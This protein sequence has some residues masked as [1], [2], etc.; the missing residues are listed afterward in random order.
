MLSD[1]SEHLVA[2]A[3]LVMQLNIDRDRTAKE[4]KRHHRWSGV[5]WIRCAFQ[6]VVVCFGCGW[7]ISG[8]NAP[9]ISRM[10]CGVRHWVTSRNHR[11]KG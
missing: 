10:S 3:P 4:V 1:R 7:I 11:L 2:G 8:R 5:L 9:L 6:S